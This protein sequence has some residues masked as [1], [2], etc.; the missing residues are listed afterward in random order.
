[1]TLGFNLKSLLVHPQLCLCAEGGRAVGARV[2]QVL[3]HSPLLHSSCLP[4]VLALMKQCVLPERAGLR[5]AATAALTHVRALP[6]AIC[7]VSVSVAAQVALVGEG[8]GA[9]VTAVR[10]V[11]RMALQVS[12]QVTPA[13]EGLATVW[14]RLN[15]GRWTAIGETHGCGVNSSGMVEGE[16]Q[17]ASY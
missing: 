16:R 5:E 17:G 4:G 1:M 12:A 8:L 13:L 14:A 6:I 15:T 10:F 9:Q 3:F 2:G 7:A 11:A